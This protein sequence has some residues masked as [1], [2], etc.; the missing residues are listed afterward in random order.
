[1]SSF[2]KKS[3]TKF[4]QI[5]NKINKNKKSNAMD[6][7]EDPSQNEEGEFQSIENFGNEGAHVKFTLVDRND[8]L[9]VDA[10]AD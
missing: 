3:K 9:R 1:M 6:D 4:D 7:H 8:M 2:L 10:E 5:K